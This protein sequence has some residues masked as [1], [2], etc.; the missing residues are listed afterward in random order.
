M[1]MVRQYY[2][3]FERDQAIKLHIC[4]CC[5]LMSTY[6]ISLSKLLKVNIR[7]C[8]LYLIMTFGYRMEFFRHQKVKHDQWS[9]YRL[10]KWNN[11]LKRIWLRY[12][13]DQC[14]I[15]K[16]APRKVLPF[17]YLLFNSW[18]K[19]SQLAAKENWNLPFM[20]CQDSEMST[21]EISIISCVLY[22]LDSS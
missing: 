22:K 17:A 16:L 5:Y 7:Y 18:E 21:F 19:T 14:Y 13:N 1:F 4:I 20:S 12:V 3:N 6:W 8:N 2:L 15:I 11:K 10:F 9:Q